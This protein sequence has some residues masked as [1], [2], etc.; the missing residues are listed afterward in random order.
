[1]TINLEKAFTKRSFSNENMNTEKE[2]GK[3]KL[4]GFCAQI[5]IIEGKK[6]S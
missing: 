2:K 4:N 5:N 1:M 3:K 6:G